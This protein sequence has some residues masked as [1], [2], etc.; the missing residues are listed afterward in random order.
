MNP[1]I[2][3]S[4]AK[5]LRTKALLSAGTALLYGASPID[6]IPDIVPVLGLVDD[7]VVVP[8]FLVLAYF[9]YRKSLRLRAAKDS[10]I[11]PTR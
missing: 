6:V 2:A 10:A 1:H 11:S 4:L 3:D 5:A 8:T 9:Q 7:A